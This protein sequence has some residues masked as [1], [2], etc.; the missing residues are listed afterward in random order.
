MGIF[1]IG[2]PWNEKLF[3]TKTNFS[4]FPP[5]QI[6]N[7][8]IEINKNKLVQKT[9]T[10]S[11]Y[12]KTWLILINSLSSRWASAMTKRNNQVKIKRSRSRMLSLSI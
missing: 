4:K 11:H 1:G 7:L 5:N 6:E 9:P 10:T 12:C 8:Q 2:R 3:I